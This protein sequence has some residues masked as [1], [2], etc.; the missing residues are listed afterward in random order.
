MVELRTCPV[1]RGRPSSALPLLREIC[2]EL[3]VC[4]IVVLN[5]SIQFPASPESSKT[6]VIIVLVEKIILTATSVQ[7]K[8]YLG[9][10]NVL[11]LGVPCC[12]GRV[13]QLALRCPV[14]PQY[15]HRCHLILR[16]CSSGVKC[17]LPTCMGS[18]SS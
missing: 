13:G 6:L 12:G 17:V 5:L 15:R 9:R 10:R 11:T 7:E 4:C 1:P 16:S 14:W 18:E 3:G 8:E 2:R